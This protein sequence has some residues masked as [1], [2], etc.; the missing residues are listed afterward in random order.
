VVA[1]SGEF[2]LHLVE[3]GDADPAAVAVEVARRSVDTPFDYAGEWPVRAAVIRRNAVPTHLV[4]TIC[5][6]ATDA[7]GALTMFVNRDPATGTPR[8]PLTAPQPLALARLQAAPAAERVHLAAMRHWAHV[9]RTMPPVRFT[10][11]ADRGTGRFRQAVY[12]SPAMLLAQHAI[13]RRVGTDLAPVM[14]AAFA[15]AVAEVEGINPVVAQIIVNNRFRPGLAE[16]VAPVSQPGLCMIDVAGLAFDDAVVAARR[17]AIGAFK[18]AYYDR[19]RLDDL[20]AGIG[21][22]RGLEL[23]LTCVY[24]DRRRAV[25]VGPA[26]T[27]AE[28]EQAVARGALRW[29]P[30][31]D[32]HN[33]KLMLHVN[34]GPGSV[35]LLA[36]VDSRFLPPATVRA[37][38]RRMESVMVAAARPV[39]DVAP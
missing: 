2:P 24:N 1:A 35:E 14:L 34:D 19:A 16:V 18:H 33:G 11:K 15:V 39:V 27:G 31:L 5:H 23:D 29:D 7:P 21:R 32:Q 30:D 9:L 6:L 36:Q 8:A 37:L 13:A 28:I 12:D 17:Q 22:E 38:V 20:I 3:A 25:P 4:V 26:S 10:A